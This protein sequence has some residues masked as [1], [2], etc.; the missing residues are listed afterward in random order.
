MSSSDLERTLEFQLR[1]AKLPTPEREY[2]FHST[3]RWRFDF[4]WPDVK[5]AVEV[6]GGT[7]AQGRHTRGP[8]FEGDCEKMNEATLMGWRV[9]RVTASMVNDGTAL[10]FIERALV[11]LDG[12]AA[13][14]AKSQKTDLRSLLEEVRT[15]G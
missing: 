6:E 14:V 1:V 10:K 13:E 9:L 12:P 8:G 7:W 4:A 3:R 2:R 11:P 15:R 5:L